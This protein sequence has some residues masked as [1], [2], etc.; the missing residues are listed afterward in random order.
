VAN[1]DA[2]ADDPVQDTWLRI[3]RGLPGLRDRARLR[4]WLFG[5]AHR[6]IIDRLRTR[7]AEPGHSGVDA[8]A[9][10]ADLQDEHLRQDQVERGLAA[11]APPDR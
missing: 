6:V 8:L 3:L 1:N 11:L 10:D 5:I 4:A 2:D 7:Y 9:D